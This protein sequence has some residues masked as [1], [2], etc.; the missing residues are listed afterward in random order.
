MERIGEYT[1]VNA[2]GLI[3][4]ARGMELGHILFCGEIDATLADK[5]SHDLGEHAL[6][7]PPAMNARRAGFLAELAW[8]R[9]RR[10]EMDD[11]E[12]LAPIYTPHESL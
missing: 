7:A 6:I 11:V 8:A 5:I 3:E 10:G 4:R 9:F 12:T 2:D 1:L